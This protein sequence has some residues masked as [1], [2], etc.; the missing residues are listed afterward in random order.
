MAQLRDAIGR[1]EE[2]LEFPEG[3]SVAHLLVELAARHGEETSPHLIT[4][5]GEPQ[6]GLLAIVNDRAVAGPSTLVTV[7]QHGDVITLM[8]PIAGG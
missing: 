3:S 1:A 4:S 2:E 5:A 8:P 7:L 6:R